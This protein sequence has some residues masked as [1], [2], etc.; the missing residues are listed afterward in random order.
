MP[1]Y[2]PSQD[3]LLLSEQAGLDSLGAVE[4]RNAIAGALGGI[5]LAGTLV[6][7]CPT[8]A[9]ITAHILAHHQPPPGASAPLAV[10]RPC[11]GR[12]SAPI[13]T[14]QLGRDTSRRCCPLCVGRCIEV[15]SRLLPPP[16][17]GCAL[18]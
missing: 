15:L 17:A 10:T 8:S 4:L 14:M 7:D 18:Q 2:I 16:P 12:L 1:L 6:F 5:E 11:S 3:G 9:A 13:K